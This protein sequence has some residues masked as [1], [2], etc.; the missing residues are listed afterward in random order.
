MYANI[1]YDPSKAGSYGGAHALWKAAGG[2][3]KDAKAWLNT[4]ETYSLHKPTRK[5]FPRNKIVVAGLDDQWEADLIDTQKLAKDNRG[6]KYI[7]SVID[8]LS[9]FAWAVPIK[10][11]TGDSLVKAFK[12]IFKDRQPR[13]LRT[14]KGK[15]FLNYKVQNL[16]KQKGIIFFTSN[17]ETKAA[18]VERFNRTLMSKVWRYFSATKQHH[19]L[20]VLP[21]L[22]KTYNQTKHSTTGI[23]PVKVTP[24]NA[25]SV[26]RKVYS[27]K[28]VKKKPTFRKGDIVRISKAKGIFEKGYKSNW[29]RE[30]FK[31]VAVLTRPIPEYRLC[32]LKGEDILGTFQGVELQR[33]QK[34]ELAVERI[35]KRKAKEVLVKWKDYPLET[36]IPEKDLKL[37]RNGGGSA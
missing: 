21:T 16:L 25:E 15:E 31:I 37:Y 7:L 36:W 8:S 3:L 20:K 10:D 34:K 19:F 5:R 30:T 27:Y 18:I 23:A 6:Q 29:T 4:Q 11:K 12:I 14:D 9:K 13:K 1:Y 28:P 26:W 35:V 17:N 2:K 33:V 24:F 32:D 22:V